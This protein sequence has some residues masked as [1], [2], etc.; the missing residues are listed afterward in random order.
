MLAAVG[1]RCGASW[2]IGPLRDGDRRPARRELISPRCAS[3]PA[4]GGGG[5]LATRPVSRLLRRAQAP[6]SSARPHRRSIAAGLHDRGWYVSGDDIDPQRIQQALDKQ[7]IDQGGLDADA[8]M[9]FVATPVLAIPD[10]ARRALAATRG[11]VSDV[12]SVKG[13]VAA[14]TDARFVGGHPMA[15][16]ELEGLDGADGEMFEGAVWVLTPPSTPPTPPSA[17][18]LRW[19]PSWCRRRRPAADRHDE[20]VAVISHVP[21]LT[22][23]TLTFSPPTA[24][25]HA[26]AALAAGGFAT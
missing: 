9:T 11:V 8:D 17:P 18:W 16:S 14:I 1:I 3:S 10:Q 2:C 24:E 5:R 23:A 13:G 6:T 21:H 4:A 12:G 22:A 20:V 26:V 19:S 15:G 25:E 7:L